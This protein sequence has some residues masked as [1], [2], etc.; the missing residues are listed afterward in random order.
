MV[1]LFIRDHPVS[2]MT[3]IEP[4]GHKRPGSLLVQA[5]FGAD[6]FKALS[7]IELG[8]PVTVITEDGKTWRGHIRNVEL[9]PPTTLRIRVG[10][11]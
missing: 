8:S 3:V 1:R 2:N 4:P 7:A 5:E 10:L 11:P 9:T 6:D